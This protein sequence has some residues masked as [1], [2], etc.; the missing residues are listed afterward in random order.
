LLQGHL[1]V[2]SPLK[3]EVKSDFSQNGKKIYRK[4]AMAYERKAA[5]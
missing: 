1:I 2:F 5:T 3:G 4:G